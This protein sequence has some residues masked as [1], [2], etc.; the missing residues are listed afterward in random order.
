MMVEL[1]AMQVH[2]IVFLVITLLMSGVEP[3][4][5][6]MLIIPLSVKTMQVMVELFMKAGHMAVL[7]LKTM[8]PI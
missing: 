5:M 1:Y 8:S 3:Y 2:M 6:V 7:S 4:V